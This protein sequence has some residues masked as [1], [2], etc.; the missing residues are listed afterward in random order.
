MAGAHKEVCVRQPAHRAAQM[1]TIHREGNELLVRD[2]AQPRGG[3]RCHAGPRQWRGILKR[4][5]YCGANREVGNFAHSSPNFWPFAQ[6]EQ[7]SD[8]RY[9]NDGSRQR[10]DGDA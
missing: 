2:S 3:L 10:T 6:T 4:H 1:G 9:R 8:A 5:L 7:E